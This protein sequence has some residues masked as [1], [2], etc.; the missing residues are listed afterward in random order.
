MTIKGKVV[1]TEQKVINTEG[2]NITRNGWCKNVN[3]TV[4]NTLRV[5]LQKKMEVGMQIEHVLCTNISI[6]SISSTVFVG[7]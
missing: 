4:T 6:K 7:L 1:K 2:T 3:R 5:N